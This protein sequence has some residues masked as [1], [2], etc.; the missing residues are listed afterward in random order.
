[1][2]TISTFMRLSR[3][4]SVTLCPRV[5]GLHPHYGIQA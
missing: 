3:G 5:A 4:V 1:M 2:D